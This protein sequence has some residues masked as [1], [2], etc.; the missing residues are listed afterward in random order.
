[1]THPAPL[2][3]TPAPLPDVFSER[4]HTLAR[5]TLPMLFGLTYG[6]WAAA[7]DRDG[8][9][10]TGWNVLLGFVSALA[11]MLVLTA[12]LV[13]APRL[14][15]EVHAATW[16]SFAGIAFGFLYSQTDESVLRSSLL[17]LPVAAAVGA[18][19]FYW[20]YTHEDEQGHRLR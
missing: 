4:T 12:V 5:R 19:A 3:E 11:F 16:A 13:T 2:S 20:H 6:Y 7:I 10:I 18:M 9:P 15:R 14:R 17:S 1:M 8:G